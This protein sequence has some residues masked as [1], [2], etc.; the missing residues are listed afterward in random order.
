MKV[1]VDTNVLV[2]AAFWDGDSNKIIEKAEKKEIELVTSREILEEFSNV[3]SYKDIQEK[4]RDKHL[5]MKR[6]VEKI[7]SISTI[8]KPQKNFNA[9]KDDP[10][11]N[12]FLDCAIAGK[13]DFIIT[14]DNHLLKLKEFEGIKVVAPGEFL[15]LKKG[16]NP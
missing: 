5:E 14:N 10:D 12:K 9:V 15:K 13:A 1:V 6:T 2:S 4:I 7:A 3:L 8:I 11:D 16:D